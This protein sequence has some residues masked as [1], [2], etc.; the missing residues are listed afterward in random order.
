MALANHSQGRSG[1][2]TDGTWRGRF[3]KETQKDYK[4]V[5]LRQEYLAGVDCPVGTSEGRDPEGD[6]FEGSEGPDLEGDA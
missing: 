2:A 1:A 5:Y 4:E 3:W 6:G